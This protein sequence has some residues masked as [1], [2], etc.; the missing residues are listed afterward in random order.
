MNISSAAVSFLAFA[1]AARP[2]YTRKAESNGDLTNCLLLDLHSKGLASGFPNATHEEN[3]ESRLNTFIEGFKEELPTEAMTEDQKKCFLNTL[4]A[5]NFTQPLFKLNIYTYADDEMIDDFDDA[6]A[7]LLYIHYVAAVN[8]PGLADALNMENSLMSSDEAYA[9]TM[10]KSEHDL[11]VEKCCARKFIL[12]NKIDGD[13][14]YEI[15][16]NPMNTTMSEVSCDAVIDELRNSPTRYS[17]ESKHNDCI[18]K[19]HNEEKLFEL[20]FRKA[21]YSEFKLTE[22]KKQAERQKIYAFNVRTAEVHHQ[23]VGKWT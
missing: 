22:K 14:E 13:P 18:A 6:Y 19:I 1:F 20:S 9:D 16:L 3:C 23:C 2:R 12:S 4:V 17:S 10:G 7:E 8:C 11:E 21:F 5:Y 15:E